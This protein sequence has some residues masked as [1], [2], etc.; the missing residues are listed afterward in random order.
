MDLLFHYEQE[1]KDKS[2]TN[3]TCDLKL[4]YGDNNIEFSSSFNSEYLKFG[5]IHGFTLNTLTGN[6]VVTY[7]LINN[8]GS[9]IK[10]FRPMIKSKKNNFT[11]LYDLTENG[12]IRGEKRV[13][14]WGINYNRAVDGL[15]GVILSLLE[16]KFKSKHYKSKHYGMKY[17]INQLYDLI[18]DFHLDMKGIKSHDNIYFDIKNDYPSKKWLQKNENNYLPSVLDSYGIKTKY[19]IGELNKDRPYSVKIKSL[20]YLCKLFGD[21]Y[22]D[23]LKQINWYNHC[24]DLPPNGKIHILKNDAEKKSMIN[25]I[26]KWDSGILQTDTFLYSVNKLLSIRETLEGKGIL[27]KFKSNGDDGFNNLMNIWGGIKTHFNRGYKIRYSFP[28]EFVEL[29]EQPIDIND[30]VFTPKILLSEDD[31]RIEGYKMKNCMSKQFMNGYLY[32]Y[33]SLEHK[34]KIVNIQFRRGRLIQSFG[35]ANSPVIHIFD[36]PIDILAKR[37]KK[38]ETLT[39]TKEKYDYLK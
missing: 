11:L 25:I 15:T 21:N 2:G 6:I 23:Y 9:E 10:I 22:I 27:L 24:T 32:I 36:K 16:P 3:S 19:F 12:F 13:G 18:V 31:F 28:N 5:D 29:I 26:K 33:I 8:Y 34:G 1:K 20:N 38:Y 17:T 7:N 14:Y 4:F 39:W 37:F 35:K 30:D